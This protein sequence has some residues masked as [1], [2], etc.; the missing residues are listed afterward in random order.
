MS[1]YSNFV[2][3][4]SWLC[5]SIIVF[6]KLSTLRNLK[7]NYVNKILFSVFFLNK[8]NKFIIDYKYIFNEK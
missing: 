6:F 2:K 1:Y 8:N 7:A 4:Y 3:F 5:T